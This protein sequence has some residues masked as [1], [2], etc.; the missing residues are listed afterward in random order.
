MKSTTLAS[1]LTQS[2]SV[3]KQ[4][5]D[6]S[7]SGWSDQKGDQFREQTQ[8]DLETICNQFIKELERLEEFINQAKSK[9][10]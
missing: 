4:K 7:K 8:S 6:D 10:P 1:N 5:I 9:V 3:L 2:F